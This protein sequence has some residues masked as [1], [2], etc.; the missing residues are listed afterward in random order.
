MSKVWRIDNNNESSRLERI[1][2]YGDV[3]HREIAAIIA[4]IEDAEKWWF[5]VVD[6]CAV[7]TDND[8]QTARNYWKWQKQ[9]NI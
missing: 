4:E 1:V 2:T 8:Y 3:L 7:L 6:I 5:S 9:A